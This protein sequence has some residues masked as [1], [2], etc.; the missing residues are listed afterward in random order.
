[1]RYLELSVESKENALDDYCDCMGVERHPIIM[2]EVAEW[3]EEYN[4]DVF[5]ADGLLTHKKR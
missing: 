5:N 3:F 4:Q 1:M 2:R